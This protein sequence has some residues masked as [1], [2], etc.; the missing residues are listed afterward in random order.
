MKKFLRAALNHNLLRHRQ[1]HRLMREAGNLAM[2]LGKGRMLMIL[3]GVALASSLLR[4]KT[5][6]A[7]IPS[8]RLD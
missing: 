6:A 5:P 2:Q 4:R 8:V 7:Q 1:H 3:G